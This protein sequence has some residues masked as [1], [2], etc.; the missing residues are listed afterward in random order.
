MV[1]F[2]VIYYGYTDAIARV[3]SINITTTVRT[4]RFQNGRVPASVLIKCIRIYPAVKRPPLVH[5]K[6]STY[7]KRLKYGPLPLSPE[8]GQYLLL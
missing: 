3:V 1:S 7:L 4:N 5:I 6:Y 8:N 2:R